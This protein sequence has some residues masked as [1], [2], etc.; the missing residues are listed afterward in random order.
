MLVLVLGFFASHGGTIPPH[1]LV[2]KLKPDLLLINESSCTIILLELTCPW[3]ANI[4]TSHTFKLEKYSP[5]VADLSRRYT[6]HYYPV[7]ISVRGQVSKS[8]RARLKS[9]VFN[10]IL[11]WIR[12]GH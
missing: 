1:V 4:A 5:L 12:C 8:N 2:S 7:E 6:V 3:D 9:L 11:L 10:G